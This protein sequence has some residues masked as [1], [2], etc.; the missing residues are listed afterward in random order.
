MIPLLIFDLDGTLVDSLRGIADSLNRTLSCH[1]LPGHSDENVR[2]FIGKGLKKLITQAVPDGSSIQTIDSALSLFQRDYHLTWA[3]GTAPYPGIQALL[4]QLQ[5][6]AHPLALLSNK[7]H[8]FTTQIV[9]HLFPSIRFEIVLGQLDGRP[10]KP[11]PAGAFEIAAHCQY[12]AA[13]CCL[14]GDS[15]ID[16]E[17]AIRAG[18]RSVAVSWGYHD[19]ER[20]LEHGDIGVVDHP[21]ELL[22]LLGHQAR[23]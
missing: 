11:D 20:L 9:A 17:T 10:N 4:E 21:H 13:N 3:N 16:I 15:S 22:T 5:E 8:D 7:A 1:G 12:P 2:K 18:M 23:N 6:E 14:I 19:R